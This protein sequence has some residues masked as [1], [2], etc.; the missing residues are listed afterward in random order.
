MITQDK[1]SWQ[2]GH[3]DG[4]EGKALG[5]STPQEEL[6]Y[7]SGYIEGTAER[8]KQARQPNVKRTTDVGGL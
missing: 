2:L 3:L 4:F 1:K 8:Q 7:V 5:A 6:A